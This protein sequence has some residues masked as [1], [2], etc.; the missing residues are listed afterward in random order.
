MKKEQKLNKIRENIIN[1]E[2]E[3]FKNTKK[4]S[5]IE[6]QKYNKNRYSIFL[7]DEYSFSVD[8]DTLIEHS[9]LKGKT[10]DDKYIENIIISDEKNKAKSKA[11]N[12]ISY[13]IRTEKEVRNKLKKLG[14]QEYEDEIIE[15]LKENN[16]INDKEYAI[17]FVK[18]RLKLKNLGKYRIKEELI[19]K[20]IIPE[21]IE[22]ALQESNYEEDEVKR[23]LF[24]IERRQKR[25]YKSEED[26]YRKIYSFLLR[27][28][29]DSEIIKKALSKSLS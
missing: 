7:N 5:K 17:F 11:L 6:K 20:G 24:L 9:I 29:Y 1:K 23:I 2:K 25:S 4:V 3:N 22:N 19:K 21:Y 18:D 10:F 26:R 27:K 14:Y 13:K 15:Y 12:Y 28:G 16:Y 8:E